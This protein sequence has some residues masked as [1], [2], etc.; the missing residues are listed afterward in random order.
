[1]CTYVECVTHVFARKENVDTRQG[2]QG[3][4]REAKIMQLT[5]SE[6]ISTLECISSNL[7]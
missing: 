7:V 3:E 5:T 1:M 6:S 2:K 4:D